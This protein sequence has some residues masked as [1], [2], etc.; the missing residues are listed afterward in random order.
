MLLGGGA[1]GSAGSQPAS[2]LAEVVSATIA[3]ETSLA[4]QIINVT[5]QGSVITLRGRV[6]SGSQRARAEA[7][8]RAVNGV[9][10]VDN[11]LAVQNGS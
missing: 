9:T 8:A 1:Q 10:D 7:L 2:G 6:A 3:G 11:R 4:G 5:G